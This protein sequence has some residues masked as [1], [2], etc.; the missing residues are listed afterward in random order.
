MSRL[1]AGEIGEWA[2]GPGSPEVES[3]ILLVASV[4]FKRVRRLADWSMRR[5][6]HGNVTGG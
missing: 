4:A 6:L 5:A 1:K 2:D 3:R